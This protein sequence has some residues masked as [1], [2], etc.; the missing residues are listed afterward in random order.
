MNIEITES[1]MEIVVEKILKKLNSNISFTE[2][3]K[4]S[5]A[6]AKAY[7]EKWQEDSGTWAIRDLVKEILERDIAKLRREVAQ[8]IVKDLDIDAVKAITVDMLRNLIEKVE[9][10]E[11]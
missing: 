2:I 5:E 3:V 11:D 4:L 1:D 8:E 10:E 7:F 6:Q 9:Y